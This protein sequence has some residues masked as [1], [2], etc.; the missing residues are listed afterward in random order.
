MKRNQSVK[1]SV[2]VP[3][4]NEEATIKRLIQMLIRQPE[5]REVL[6]VND[7][8]T[9]KTASI[10]KKIKHKK[11]RCIS[12][13][14]NK[15]KGSAIRTALHHATGNYVLIQDADLEYDPREIPLLLAPIYSG[16]A[17]IVFGSRF[18]GTHSN[19]FFWHYV[20][21]KFLNFIVNILYDNIL[22]DMETCY[23]LVPTEVMKRLDLKENDF[24]IEPEIVCKLLLSNERIVEVPITYI[25]RT[26]NE[27]KKLTWIDGFFAI[28]TIIRL[29]LGLEKIHGSTHMPILEPLL[30]EL[31]IRKVLAVMKTGGVLVDVGCDNPPVFL[32]RVENKMKKCVGLDIVAKPQTYRNITILKQDLQK[33]IKL[34]SNSANVVTMM[35]VLEHMKHP[36]EMVSECYRILRKGGQLLVTVPAPKNKPVL[37]L[38]SAIGL[39][40]KEMI[41][42]HENYFTP[43]ILKKLSKKAGFKRIDV[44]LFELGFNTFLQATK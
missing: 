1:L 8:S 33:K 14:T 27:G 41:D 44:S 12:H 39:V 24:R 9:D 29:R 19:M 4:Y 43:E 16:R 10:L 5:V 30:Q 31:R 35:A 17:S 23:K 37:E 11:L 15:G 32:H 36:Q 7:A 34:P 18:F 40:R 6:V 20:G 13:K 25:G 42:Q 38:F 22:S 26:Y 28:G 21:N 3:A 2:I